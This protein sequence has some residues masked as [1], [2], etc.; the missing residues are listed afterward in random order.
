[1]KR[2]IINLCALI[3]MLTLIPVHLSAKEATTVEGAS[4]PFDVAPAYEVL[5]R[6]LPNHYDQV[7]FTAVTSGSTG[8]Y[9]RIENKNGGVHISGTSPAVIL[10]GFNWYLKYIVKA[11]INWNGEQLNL[12]PQL[13]LPETEIIRQANVSHRLAFNDTDDGYTGPYRNWQDWEHMIDVLALNGINE[14]LVTVGQEAVYYD[15]FQKFG[16]SEQ[17][18]LDWI[19]QPA[20]Q[21]WWLLQNMCCFGGSISDQLINE[22]AELGKKIA[23]RLRE[24]GMTPVFPGYFGTVPPKFV[25]KNPGAQIVPQG[26]WVGFTRPDWLDPRNTLFSRVAE[27]FYASQEELFGKTTMFKMDLL[28]EGGNPGNVPVADAAKAVENTLQTAHPGAIWTILGWQSNP[29]ST[30]LSKLDKSKVLIL[31]G[32]SDRYSNLNQEQ[33]WS[34]TPYAFGSIWN[35]GGHTTMGANL[36]VWNTRYW[37]WKNKTGS[38]LSGI[39]MMPEA[40]ENNPVAF[41]FFTEMA[42]QENP[43]DLELWFNAW[44]ERRYGGVDEHAEDAWQIIRNTAYQMPSDGWS[45]AQD[46]LF[47]AQPSL[48]ASK[49]AL[50][51]P[52]NM[53]YDATIFARALPALLEVAPEFRS[54]SAYRYD[55]MD[56]ARQVLSNHSR[57]LLP[58]IKKAYDD[59]DLTAFAEITDQ[60][61]SY[62]ELLDELLATNNQTMLGPW[63]ERA[64]SAGADEAEKAR[65]EYNARSLLTVWG[66]RSGSVGGGLRDYANREW[67][68]LVGDYYYTRWET[69]FEELKLALQ[70][71]RAPRSIDW[72]VIGDEWSSRQNMYPTEPQGDVYEIAQRVLEELSIPSL[73]TV[74]VTSNRTVIN[75]NEPV[76]I[77]AV[78]SND[79]SFLPALDVSIEVTPSSSFTVHSLTPTE[80]LELMPGE[81]FTTQFE[82]VASNEFILDGLLKKIEIQAS[83]RM[84]DEQKIV[85]NDIQLMA[86][87]NIEAP[88]RTVSFNNA[89]FGKEG[90]TFGI[91]GGGADL[92]NDYY[93]FGSIYLD[94]A[95]VSGT[96]AVTQVTHQE[97]TWGWARA[98]LMARNDLTINGSSGF[99]NIAVTP[100][101]GCAFSWDSDNNGRLDSVTSKNGFSAP[102]YVKLSR[103]GNLYTGFCSSD[104]ITWTTVGQANLQG[105]TEAQDI[106]LFM[107]AVNVVSNVNGLV[108]FKDFI[109]TSEDIPVNGITVDKTTASIMEG[110]TLELSAIISPE[111]AFN[112]KVI[113]SS[114]DESVASIQIASSGKANVKGLKPGRATITVTSEDGGYQAV[115]EIVVFKRSANLALHKPASA[116]S[117]SRPPAMGN[118]GEASTM[119]IAS[120]GAVGEW[121]MVDLEDNYDLA[122]VEIQF[123]K[124]VIWKYVIEVSEDQQ[125][126]T[127]VVNKM[128]NIDTSRVQRHAVAKKGRYV[129]ITFNQAPGTN[130]TAFQELAVYGEPVKEITTV[131]QTSHTTVQAGQTFEV[132]YGLSEVKDRILAQDIVLN[133]DSTLFEYV[134]SQPVKGGIFMYTTE[135]QEA[136]KL[137][138]ILASEG[139]QHAIV[140]NTNVVQLIFNAKS[141]SQQATG[142]IEVVS[143]QLSNELGVESFAGLSSLNI[144]VRVGMSGDMN[145][146]GKI[147]I[148]DLAF[149]A[150]HYGAKKENPNWEQIKRAD[151][152][153]DGV[154]DI[155]DLA[156]I[157][158]LIITGNS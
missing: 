44:S 49:A 7:Q 142:N 27:E 39:A 89:Q 37:Q 155:K 153:N 48:T 38:M 103:T 154:I 137:R 71:N 36:S 127:T 117:T 144:E 116:K 136:G 111:N 126:W 123:E 124:E 82:V 42:W 31:D 28:H 114:S 157:A 66:H 70:E 149:V 93:G 58:Q 143:A 56:V 96:T 148:G 88:Y 5:E 18:L 23:N 108:T 50:W 55:L 92:W 119:W 73:L 85:Q 75:A 4:L 91:F 141:T 131:L 13:P 63:L 110:E 145:N 47:G 79:N 10:T 146:D 86:S 128:E 125:N 113:W 64:K 8:D 95:Y 152:N 115:S 101:N 76:T 59:K 43:A 77:T 129:R 122:A 16:Y 99:V 29:S 105:A 90:D 81:S 32:L 104:G 102:A 156:E 6:L 3:I 112:R 98:G 57:K 34:N 30:F 62:M 130:W 33:N 35:F 134:T 158:S 97:N 61:L 68:G 133:Y 41:D 132:I 67:A 20:H 150:A 54:S 19:P 83:Y 11:N 65:L 147:S 74:S 12:P 151:F 21:P 80:V 120:S 26:S 94:N 69:Y 138:L 106:G 121:W 17:E 118:D 25:E 139:E 140:N 2:I 100:G 1:M 14:V 9:F 52:D 72:F 84:G 51:S 107:S 109:L 24:L 45:E 46:G 87:S 135:D 22:R 78:M 15:T 53:R 60:W 40:S